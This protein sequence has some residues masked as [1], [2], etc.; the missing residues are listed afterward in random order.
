MT[1]VEFE[2]FREALN[3]DCEEILLRKGHDYAGPQDRFR[4][5]RETAREVGIPAAKVWWIFFQKHL[6]AISTFVRDGEV[7]SEPIMERFKDARNYLDL[8]AGLVAE[9]MGA[10]GVTCESI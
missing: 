5:F 8:G 3:K 4:N 10:G 6:H 9:E 1:P 7:Q 2:K